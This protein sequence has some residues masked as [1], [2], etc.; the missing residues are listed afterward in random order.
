MAQYD[1]DDIT[2]MNEAL[3][4]DGIM[5]D[6]RQIRY[7][8]V[9]KSRSDAKDCTGD[10]IPA[11]VYYK[12]IEYDNGDDTIYLERLPNQS[13]GDE[14]YWV[15][16]QPSDNDDDDDDDGDALFD[17][18]FDYVSPANVPE[19]YRDGSSEDDGDD[20]D[21][22]TWR[23]DGKCVAG[24][25]LI[26]MAGAKDYQNRSFLADTKWIVKEID[27]DGTLELREEGPDR[28][29][30]IRKSALASFTIDPDRYAPFRVGGQRVK[31]NDTIMALAGAKDFNGTPI[32]VNVTY[33]V[34]GVDTSDNTLKIYETGNTGY[35]PWVRAQDLDKFRFATEAEKRETI[36]PT[37][38]KCGRTKL[39]AGDV[40]LIGEGVKTFDNCSIQPGLWIIASMR[41]GTDPIARIQ[42]IDGRGGGIGWNV[43]PG[44]IARCK[45][46][47]DAD[48]RSFTPE[49]FKIG[50]RTLL[51]GDQIEAL[52][53]AKTHD[54]CDINVGIWTV[55]RFDSNAAQIVMIVNGSRVNSWWIKA[56][57]L[58]KFKLVRSE[59]TSSSQRVDPDAVRT[60]S[61]TTSASSAS[62]KK[63]STVASKS[64]ST[65]K[66]F[67]NF[68]FGVNDDPNLAITLDGK[69]AVQRDEGIFASYQ[70]GEL[71]EVPEDFVIKREGI[72]YNMPAT[73]DQ[74]KP[75]D[76]IKDGDL[77]RVVDKVENGQVKVVN[78]GAATKASLVTVK[79]LFGFNFYTR[80]TSIMGDA[81]TGGATGAAGM[82][83]LML[84]VFLGDEGKGESKDDFMTLMIMSQMINP[85]AQGVGAGIGNLF[86]GNP[87]M[88]FML[89][90][91]GEKG[92]M[93]D[94]LKMML[95]GQM[96]T[97]QPPAASTEK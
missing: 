31:Q 91:K 85:G 60:S 13:Q 84:M 42:K 39:K 10:R 68:D 81:L 67:L 24:L 20:K 17:E 78:P 66:S 7:G 43:R 1:S 41:N 73:V 88:A 72:L 19:R 70:N 54:N 63:E 34:G 93:G 71:L 32:H 11:D 40:I 2:A 14:N 69:I 16:T 33:K 80:V 6:G 96:F 48:K 52:P 56:E 76:V 9:V 77:Y 38:F 12:V 27:S 45:V 5:V 4:D 26:P 28:V 30:W 23:I 3:D 58:S 8:S 86:G 87:M 55:E 95:M 57:C 90:G 82:N 47:S 46:A 29:R 65:R 94:M 18:D 49:G 21:I 37:E 22:D 53:G 64:S 44:D 89:L 50:R 92:G 15:K 79:N 35:A 97:Q 25:V 75:G 62:S 61:S 36:P 74:L 51:L 59:S 83:P